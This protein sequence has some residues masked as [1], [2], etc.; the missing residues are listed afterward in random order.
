MTG[1]FSVMQEALSRVVVDPELIFMDIFNIIAFLFIR[2]SGAVS[3]LQVIGRDITYVLHRLL[4]PGFYVSDYMTYVVMEWPHHVAMGYAPST[5]G[6]FYL[7][8]GT[9]ALV[10]GICFL[11]IATMFIWSSLC[12]LSLRTRP[13]ALAIFLMYFFRLFADGTWSG[14]L[15]Q[16][17]ALIF[18][19]ALCEL[20]S[21]YRIGRA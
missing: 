4:E 15:S 19:M 1:N 18:V 5:F 11:I 8:G 17:P 16:L 2:F 6:F 7:L 10:T 14:V 12:R 21:R 20:L 13:V 9:F 3:F